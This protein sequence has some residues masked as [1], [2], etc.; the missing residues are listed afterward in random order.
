MLARTVGLVALVEQKIPRKKIKGLEGIDCESL[1]VGS[2]YYYANPAIASSVILSLV[3]LILIK[4]LQF[5][6][7]FIC[8]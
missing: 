4:I 5:P 3:M 7:S 2:S 6:P 1:D 8:I